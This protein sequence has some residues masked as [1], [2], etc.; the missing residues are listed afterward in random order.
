M[1]KIFNKLK[2]LKRYLVNHYRFFISKSKIKKL[3]G[4]YSG[5][6][7]FI[8]GN[9]PSLDIKDLE[10]LKNEKCFASHRVYQIFNQTAWRPTFYCAQDKELINNSARE[11]NLISRE[12]KSFIGLLPKAKYK[13][14]KKANYIQLFPEEFFPNLPSFSEEVTDYIV[15]GGTVTYMCLQLA[16][17]MGFTEIY[18]LGI[19]HSYSITLN[20]DGTVNKHENVKDHFSN[21][22]V[23]TNVP[24]LYKSSLAYEAAKK[25]S[26]ERGIRIFNVTRG[27]KLEA[28]ERLD[29]DDL[30]V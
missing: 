22:D 27:G 14:I 5:E 2:T 15:E 12:T 21:E 29:F 9:G 20:P 13:K 11:I 25:Y 18:L 4:K 26:D 16:V 28:F 1:K 10:K 24:V 7:C 3:K 8:I 19:D 23:L 17:Y 6:R 30:N